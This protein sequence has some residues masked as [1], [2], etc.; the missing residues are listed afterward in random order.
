MSDLCEQ[1]LRGENV[2]NDISVAKSKILELEVDRL[3]GYACRFQPVS[4]LENEK[5]GLFTL[6]KCSKGRKTRRHG[7]SKVRM[8]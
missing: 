1:Q 7:L 3:R 2:G 5:V 8:V 4:L 6:R